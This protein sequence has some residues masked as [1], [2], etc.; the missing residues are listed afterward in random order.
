MVHQLPRS[1]AEPGLAIRFWL[2][3]GDRDDAKFNALSLPGLQEAIG[4]DDVEVELEL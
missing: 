3:D 2:A 4:R 1:A